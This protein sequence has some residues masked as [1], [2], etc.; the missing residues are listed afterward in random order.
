MSG[1]GRNEGQQGQCLGSWERST[2]GRRLVLF[3]SI[4]FLWLGKW[5]RV[6]R[7]KNRTR[8]QRDTWLYPFPCLRRTQRKGE[9]AQ[10]CR[11]TR[12]HRDLQ[13]QDKGPRPQHVWGKLQGNV[14]EHRGSGEVLVPKRK[15]DAEMMLKSL[16]V[17]E[18]GDFVDRGFCLFSVGLLKLFQEG[19]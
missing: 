10:P 8:L 6:R 9:V 5:Q 13:T 19:V 17:G 12:G 18:R 1:E 3:S 15:T 2:R 11:G 16:T 4:L 14:L 7:R